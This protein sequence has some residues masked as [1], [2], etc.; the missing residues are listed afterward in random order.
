MTSLLFSTARTY[1]LSKYPSRPQPD[2]INI[3]VQ[4]LLPVSVGVARLRVD[5]ISIGKRYS[6]AQ[7]TVLKQKGSSCQP[8]VTAIITQGNLATEV[9]QTIT[10]PPIIPK[11]EIP[12]RET[13]CEEWIRPDW[14]AKLLPVSTKWR[15]SRPKGGKNNRFLSRKGLNVKETWMR[16]AD[17]KGKLDIISLGTV[18]DNVSMIGT[19]P[20]KAV[21][22]T[23]TRLSKS[24]C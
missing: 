5:E 16:W 9:G 8:C 22:D 4:F 10:T 6:T 24:T 23:R 15:T 3:H 13:A 19:E 18:C 14:L 7:I 12:D 17:E 2:P 21:G 20:T 11:K 1:F